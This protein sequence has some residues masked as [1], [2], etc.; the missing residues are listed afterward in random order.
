MKLAEGGA[1]GD[2]QFADRTDRSP[3]HTTT[4][5]NINMCTNMHSF[6]SCQCVW[7]KI[8]MMASSDALPENDSLHARFVR[9][10]YVIVQQLLTPSEVE[11][12]R[13][14]AHALV[15]REEAAAGPDRLLRRRL[16]LVRVL[17][18]GV[19]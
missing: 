8:R 16:E 12:L 7:E 17:R 4:H 18:E 6:L 9:D 19:E 11:N 5:T 2:P 14:E 3:T 10:G 13:S 1:V 15:A